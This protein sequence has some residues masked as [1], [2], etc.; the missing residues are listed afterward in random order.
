MKTTLLFLLCFLPASA[1]T[2][3][4]AIHWER[5]PEY[6]G[7]THVSF[8][9]NDTYLFTGSWEKGVMRSSDKGDSWEEVNEG[10][11]NIKP[12]NNDYRIT[13]IHIHVGKL[14]AG[15]DSGKVYR[16]SD[17]GDTWVEVSKGLPRYGIRALGS[18]ENVLLAG[19]LGGGIYKST[20]NGESWIPS[21]KGLTIKDPADSLIFTFATK[22]STIIV[23]T[24]HDGIF[25]STDK[26]ETWTSQFEISPPIT[27][28]TANS[29]TFYAG[30]HFYGAYRSVDDGITW[31]EINEGLPSDGMVE[32]IFATETNVFLGLQPSGDKGVFHSVTNGDKWTADE[33]LT[34]IY[35]NNFT[36]IGKTIF[37]W[38]TSGLYRGEI[39]VGL[40]EATLLSMHITP[41][42]S[43]EY[44]SVRYDG[45]GTVALRDILG[46]LRS[47]I[48]PILNG[49]ARIPIGN[50]PSG[51]YFVEIRDAKGTCN[52]QKVLVSR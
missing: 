6:L 37:A 31:D 32:T 38:T 2:L 51:V 29:T 30:S 27:Q 1:T 14:F 39:P 49:E 45:I 52:A 17:N 8:A 10:L 4:Q 47:P 3:A 13:S 33:E 44:F 40:E 22:D 43:S 36:A 11:P 34:N 7:G 25:R 5:L 35:A 50:A 26:G 9:I 23:G 41:N 15:T 24:Q 42:P 19:T 48:L 12:I 21:N 28:L 18:I 20:D 46:T 16:S